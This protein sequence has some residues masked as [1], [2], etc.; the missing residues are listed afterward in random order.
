MSNKTS[1]RCKWVLFL[2]CIFLLNGRRP[3]FSSQEAQTETCKQT[4]KVARVFP[5]NPVWSFRSQ[6]FGI[7]NLIELTNRAYSCSHFDKKSP[8]TA[9][10]EHLV[11]LC[12]QNENLVCVQQRST[13]SGGMMMQ[14]NIFKCQLKSSKHRTNLNVTIGGTNGQYLNERP[15]IFF[16]KRPAQ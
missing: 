4:R 13:A 3:S 16:K 2:I 1:M 15:L 6:R 14:I 5:C 11:G 7:H 10:C 9:W 8:S 12:C